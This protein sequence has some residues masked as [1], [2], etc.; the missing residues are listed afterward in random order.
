MT[1][2]RLFPQQLIPWAL[3]ALVCRLPVLS[4][5]VLEPPFNYNINHYNDE[6]VKKYKKC[7][8]A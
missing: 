3:M 8:Y 4:V 5:L 6:K 7:N 1:L 2:N